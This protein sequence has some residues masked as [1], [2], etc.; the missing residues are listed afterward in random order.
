MT[1]K[2]ILVWLSSF[3]FMTA[4][5]ILALLEYYESEEN[6]FHAFE[7]NDHV[8][9]EILNKN[10]IEIIQNNANLQYVNNFYQNLIDMNIC[11]VTFKDSAYPETLKN[12]NDFPIVLYT[13]GNLKLLNTKSLAVVGTRNPTIY[14]KTV[15]YDIVKNLAK[16]GITI[17]S[18]MAS[19][20]DSISH[21]ACLEVGGNTVAVLGSGFNQIYP[22]PVSCRSL[23]RLT[24]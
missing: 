4:K 19:G 24:A 21:K 23:M 17:V 18:G 1:D 6:V 14:G 22:N 3:E 5:K 7:R 11:V 8:L 20:I 13:K 2:K 16:S 15:T 10:Q 12:I 9:S